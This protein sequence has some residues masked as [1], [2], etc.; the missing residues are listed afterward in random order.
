[1]T[2]LSILQPFREVTSLQERI[3]QIFRDISP[4]M[5]LFEQSLLAPISL[6][7]KTDIYEEDDK[8]VL[9][10]EAPGLRQEEI[11]LT[12]EGNALTISGEHKQ[13][14][15]RKKGRYQRV[16]RSYGSFSRTFVL[17]ATVD[18]NSIEAQYEHG[19]LHISMVKKMD[20]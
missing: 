11:S 2:A 1:M 20:A 4:E 9:E 8:V 12:V 7:P 6:T 19:I 14:E 3:N 17:P 15:E 13:H 16:E 5:D 18:A 10:M